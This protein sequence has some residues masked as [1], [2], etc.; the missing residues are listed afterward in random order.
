M[1]KPWYTS[2]TIIFFALYAAVNVA[3]L[4]GFMEWTPSGEQ[5]EIVGVLVSAIAVALRFVTREP[6]A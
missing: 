2:K 5:A 3:G 6:V 4:F 1:G